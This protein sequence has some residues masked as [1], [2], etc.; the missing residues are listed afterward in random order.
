MAMFNNYIAMLVYQRVSFD[1]SSSL[2]E[3][4]G[5]AIRGFQPTEVAHFDSTRLWRVQS[6]RS[7]LVLSLHSKPTCALRGGPQSSS[8]I[9]TKII[10]VE[11][12]TSIMRFFLCVF[13]N[14]FLGIDT[15]RVLVGFGDWDDLVQRFF[16]GLR[17]RGGTWWLLA[18]DFRIVLPVILDG[19][20]SFF[21]KPIL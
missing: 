18:A 16:W 5:A 12:I 17:L 7:Q 2:R 9:W 10:T 20:A 8:A 15:G 19:L 4:F 3:R 14:S 13:F 6:T 1:E 21:F 11:S